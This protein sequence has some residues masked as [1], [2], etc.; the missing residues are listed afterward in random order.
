MSVI[1]LVRGPG[2]RSMVPGDPR[3]GGPLRA[4]PA[5]P[6][7]EGTLSVGGMAP[8]ALAERYGTPLYVL[9]EA[10]VRDRARAWRRALPD[11]DIVHTAGAFWCRA[12][13]DWMA[14]EG[15]GLGVRTAAERELAACRGFPAD[16]LVL[17]GGASSPQDL[18]VA[19]RLGVGR[20]VIGSYGEIA[21][22]AARVT[23][24]EPQQVL[25]RVDLGTGA[26]GGRGARP[27]AVPGR[28]PGLPPGGAGFADAVAA[29]LGQ[30]ALEL[31]GLH[32]HL[33][34]GNVPPAAHARAV[35]R[36][37]GLLAG[38]RERH[39]V[40]LP[41]LD[42]GGGFAVA[43]G[44]DDPAPAPAEYGRRIRAAVTRACAAYDFPP[45]RLTVEP[46][47]SVTGPAAIA[48]H[49]VLTVERSGGRRTFSV[50]GGPS[51]GPWLGQPGAARFAMERV[52]SADPAGAGSVPVEWVCT[53][54]GLPAGVALLPED[55]RPGDVV[56]VRGAAAYGLSAA[57]VHGLV[58]RPPLV[59][60]AGGRSRLLVRRET[61]EDHRAR[62]VGL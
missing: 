42:L 47:R 4:A 35:R 49:R 56:A 14:E 15:L 48:L 12:V 22:I 26:A 57:G 24:P 53:A 18:A 60:V 39:G 10:A 52:G 44:P 3:P 31:V 20:I 58:A 1:P 21:R 62:D 8:A 61:F 6:A 23:G 43:G 46:G 55:L 28:G 16:R 13:V 38:V 25:V 34:P 11:A 33:G 17:H 54:G 41:E 45:P 59:A 19:L 32:T 40:T 9:D 2:R 51:A 50:D 37:V 7:P 30:P 36:L 27:G 5:R 29:V